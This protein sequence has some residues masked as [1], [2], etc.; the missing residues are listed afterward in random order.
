MN[1][2]EPLTNCSLCWGE[3][4]KP[5]HVLTIR[6]KERVVCA[7]CHK[8]YSKKT[9][10]ELDK[11]DIILQIGEEGA[12]CIVQ[13]SREQTPWKFPKCYK[14]VENALATGDYT[15]RGWEHL[16]TIDRKELNDFIGCTLKTNRERFKRELKRMSNYPSA[17]I[18]IE[19]DHAKIAKGEYTSRIPPQSV[20]ASIFSWS[21]EFGVKFYCAS[22]RRNSAKVAI[23]IFDKFTK[24][25]IKKHNKLVKV[26][27]AI[28]HKAKR[29]ERLNK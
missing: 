5:P 1:K 12:F 13:D 24:N 4:D 18:V 22:D 17:W 14:V 29:D 2:T 9:I 10:K 7:K 20:I 19:S 27:K 11:L 15:L 23:E 6:K 25:Y 26:S 3:L 21:E 28:S 8:R 16:V